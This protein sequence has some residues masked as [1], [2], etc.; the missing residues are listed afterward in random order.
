MAATKYRSETTFASQKSL[1]SSTNLSVEISLYVWTEPPTQKRQQQPPKFRQSWTAKA[2]EDHKIQARTV[3]WLHQPNLPP[4]DW[5]RPKPVYDGDNL[6]RWRAYRNRSL[7]DP[8][9]PRVT[10]YPHRN[11]TKQ[12]SPLKFLMT[13]QELPSQSSAVRINVGWNVHVERAYGDVHIRR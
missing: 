8:I 6:R 10:W 2:K 4:R 1:R 5:C 12:V 7:S 11:G 13:H 3:R 9:K